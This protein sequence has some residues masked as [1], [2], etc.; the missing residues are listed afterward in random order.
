MQPAPQTTR[1]RTHLRP[2]AWLRRVVARRSDS[3][4]RT[5]AENASDLVS[6]LDRDGRVLFA[7]ANWEDLLGWPAHELEGVSAFDFLEAADERGQRV[8]F[9]PEVALGTIRPRVYRVRHRDGSHRWLEFNAKPSTT[10]AGKWCVIGYARDVTETQRLVA[11]LR[12]SE[13]RYRTLVES[14]GDLVAELDADGCALYVNPAFNKALG[15]V[16]GELVGRRVLD[17][18]HPEDRPA[19]AELLGR[20]GGADASAG[21]ALRIR[22]SDGAWCELE[23][24]AAGY[25]SGHGEPRLV[26]IG[27]DVTERAKL[28]R[29]LR[30]RA[31]ELE[32]EV[33]VRVEQL[34]EANTRLLE[35]R[36]RLALIQRLSA[37]EN[38]A[39]SVAHSINNP[40][41]ALKGVVQMALEAADGSDATL[42][43]VLHLARRIERV[44]DGTLGFFRRGNLQLQ[45]RSPTEIL[46]SVRDELAE[47]AAA[48][49]VRVELLAGAAGPPIEVDS[50]LLTSALVCIAENALEAMPGGGGLWLEVE[51]R[52]E[53][54][55]ALRI[56]DNGPG[57]PIE[58]RDKVLEPFFTTKGGG[59]GLGLAIADRIIRG[60]HGNISVEERRGGGAAVTVSL[61]IAP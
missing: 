15:Y 27:R 6:V 31:A 24:T 10:S 41:A 12:G 44:V 13:Q 28:E 36:S 26:V 60:H 11:Q 18:L 43:R 48:C 53:R 45:A 54:A 5:L 3:L 59:T 52:D 33:D 46:E 19:G 39:G 58:L 8:S 47:R 61:P 34:A 57:I 42:D 32:H 2:L 49:G 23:A 9:E 20:I 21:L 55:V 51:E 40:L 50:T 22:R 25:R 29:D 1:S 37:P 17:L 16:E 30:L 38:L 7:S 14:A 4:Y 35:L 56:A